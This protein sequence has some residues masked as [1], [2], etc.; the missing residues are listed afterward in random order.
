MA[1]ICGEL[2]ALEIE[3]FEHKC[4]VPLSKLQVLLTR[5][6]ILDLL[7]ESDIKFYDR[8][9]VTNA[10]LNNGLRLFATLASIRNID[11]IVRFLKADYFSGGQFDSKLPMNES[12]LQTI[13]QNEDISRKFFR[14]QWT[15][16]APVLREDQSHRELDDRTIM[17]FLSSTPIGHGG[18]ANVF[19]V[20]VDASH[21]QILGAQ[22][23]VGPPSFTSNFLNI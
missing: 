5:E 4:F 8:N 9:E 11:C 14:K 6:R 21:H 15:F 20:R 12:N 2:D 18:F 3:N 23:E 22:S 16:L 1:D 19:K 17:P 10:V 13:L 7:Q